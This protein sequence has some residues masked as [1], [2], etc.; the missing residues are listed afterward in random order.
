MQAMRE[1][2]GIGKAREPQ[3][4]KKLK[5]NGKAPTAAVYTKAYQRRLTHRLRLGL[6]RDASRAHLH[7]PY[8][9]CTN[10]PTTTA[11]GVLRSA[12]MM[13]CC[14][15]NCKIKVKDHRGKP[16]GKGSLCCINARKPRTMAKRLWFA[17]ETVR[18]DGGRDNYSQN[19]QPRRG[20]CK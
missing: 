9:V 17:S 18:P 7:R 14:W 4:R 2:K 6:S 13:I 11:T 20:G 16:R 19:I 5:R 12:N 3:T 15:R 8:S 1:V 10:A